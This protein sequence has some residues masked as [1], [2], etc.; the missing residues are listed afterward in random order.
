MMKAPPRWTEAQLALEA[1]KSAAQFRQARL[2]PS[3]QWKTH[4]DEAAKQFEAL[5]KLLGDLGPVGM[6]DTAVA[7]A[8][9]EDLSEAL[10][11]LAG[12]FISAGDLKV[13]ADVTSLAP[14]V[15]GNSPK[16][17]KQAFA[18]IKTRD[19]RCFGGTV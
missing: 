3:L 2:K 16:R 11:Y 5:F 12:P 17:A 18:L 4:V 13:V 10:R 14:N 1:R 6:T 8:F 19:L 15:I 9:R 7:K